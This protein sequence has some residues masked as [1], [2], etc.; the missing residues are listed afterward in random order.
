MSIWDSVFGNAKKENGSQQEAVNWFELT[1]SDQLRSLIEDS[2][3]KSQLIFKHSM[4]CGVSGMTK[5]RFE[6]GA[7]NFKDQFAFHLLVVQ[8][9][10]DLSAQIGAQFQVRHES[11]QLLIIRDGAV[12]DHASHWQ[13]DSLDLEKYQ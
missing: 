7:E 13:I 4:T 3:N 11:P 1:D 6:A 8:K 10:R 12:V 9:N 2:H 5:R